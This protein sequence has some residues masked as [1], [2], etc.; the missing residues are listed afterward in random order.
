VVNK[1]DIVPHMPPCE[2]VGHHNAFGAKDCSPTSKFFH[3]G[4]EIWFE[5][6]NQSQNAIFKS[7]L[8]PNPKVQVKIKF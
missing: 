1:K 5:F 3:H 7:D 2:K 8:N 4:H 6:N